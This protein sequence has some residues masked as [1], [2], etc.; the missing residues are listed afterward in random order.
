MLELTKERLKMLIEG[1]KYAA[2]SN[3]PNWE[4]IFRNFVNL[5]VA[6]FGKLHANL[7]LRFMLEHQSCFNNIDELYNY[8]SDPHSSL[9]NDNS[10]FTVDQLEQLFPD[11]NMFKAFQK[12]IKE[13][14]NT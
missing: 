3:N 6:Q 7:I 2:A 4:N 13:H 10:A 12:V 8:I 1:V 5:L 9:I 14:T 11:E